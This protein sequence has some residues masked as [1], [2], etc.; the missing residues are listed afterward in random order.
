MGKR[1]YQADVV[2][3]NLD[4]ADSMPLFRQLYIALRDAILSGQLIAGARLPATRTMANSLDVARNTV[5]NAY[6]QLRVEGYLEGRI[7]SGTVVARDLRVDYPMV[8]GPGQRE[9]PTAKSAPPHK[10]NWQLTAQAVNALR[11]IGRT[12]RRGDGAFEVDTPALDA[13]PLETLR[14]L[15]AP[16]GRSA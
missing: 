5:I 16:T 14:R 13:L 12:P 11:F 1:A 3:I 4:R 2:P 10:R 7:G 8:A 15:R 6:E 9:H